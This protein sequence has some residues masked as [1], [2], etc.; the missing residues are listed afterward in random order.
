MLNKK[1]VVS[2]CRGEHGDP[3]AALGLHADGK[4]R[5]SLCSLQPGA[6]A[7]AA[8]D[9]AT[10]KV[11]VDLAERKIDGLGAHSGFFEAEIPGRKE[12]FAYRL[13]IT[14]AGGVQEIDDPYRFSTV[15]GEVDVWLLA[16]GSHLRPYERL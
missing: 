6:L 7:V 16:E 13:R 2:L 15:L 9:A 8:V 3:F 11:L 4:G 12:A 5:L 10:G 14:W 1:E